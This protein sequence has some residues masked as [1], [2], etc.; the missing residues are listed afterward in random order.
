MDKGRLGAGKRGPSPFSF[1]LFL[2]S[3]AEGSGRFLAIHGKL[4][5]V[6]FS[7]GFSDFL[8]SDGGK[9][10]VESKRGQVEIFANVNVKVNGSLEA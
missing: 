6:R 2:F 7:E 10:L 4:E 5:R 9:V 3:D 8:L 1:P